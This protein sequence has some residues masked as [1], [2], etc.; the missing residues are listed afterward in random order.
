MECLSPVWG[1]DVAPMRYL[2]SPKDFSGEE[3]D[4]LEIV[5]AGQAGKTRFLFEMHRFRTRI[6]KE[7]MGW[8]VS[9]T[10]DGLEV[11]QFDLPDSIY[12]LALDEDKKVIGTW[13]LLSTDGPTMIHDVWPQ[14]LESIEM[15]KDPDVWETS[16]F[17][18]NSPKGDTNE[19]LAQVNQVT[20]ELFCGI[21]ELSLL[22]GIRE[23]YSMYDM[24][25]ARILKRMD[26]RP[27]AVSK[28]IR[29]DDNFAQVGAFRMN[30]DL[31]ARFR[32]A[33]G[34]H[35]TLITEDMLPPLLQARLIAQ[36]EKAKVHDVLLQVQSAA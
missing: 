26:C 5:Q 29:I 19:G 36:K 10:E 9:I 13:R 30:E 34:I 20:G 31:L 15:P 12:M 3:R 4:M 8:E 16:R 23:I 27:K 17:A 18:A 11:D 6:F 2:V 35:H 25:M 22:C 24:R 14:F 1:I 21:A 33:S 28:Q 7:K 32:K